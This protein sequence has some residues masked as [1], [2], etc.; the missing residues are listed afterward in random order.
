MEPE[1]AR[2]RLFDSIATFFKNASRSQPIV[3]VLDDLHW[4]D[5]S[6]LLLLEFVAHQMADSSLLLIGTYRDVR[7]RLHARIAEALEGLHGADV[8]ADAVELAHH[9]TE[10]E[11][12]AGPEKLVRYS[13]LAGEQA[14]A[15]YAYE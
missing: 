7:V 5:T 2:F 4:S 8:E 12:V 11:A 14:L 15:T 9:F 13:L 3:R 1:S 10:V 6:S